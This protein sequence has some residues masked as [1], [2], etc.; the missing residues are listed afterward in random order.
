MLI[1]DA[2]GVNED[3]VSDALMADCRMC[4]VQSS[5]LCAMLCAVSHSRVSCHVCDLRHTTDGDGLTRGDS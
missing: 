3:E 5:W 2:S 1:C 4:I